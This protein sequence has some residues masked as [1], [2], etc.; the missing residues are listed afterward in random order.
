MVGREGQ[1][2]RRRRRRYATVP[3]SNDGIIPMHKGQAGSMILFFF[4]SVYRQLGSNK[5]VGT[6]A[7]CKILLLKILHNQKND[8]N[9]FEIL[10]LCLSRYPWAH[11]QPRTHTHA[12]ANVYPTSLPS[13]L[14]IPPFLDSKKSNVSMCDNSRGSSTQRLLKVP[15]LPGT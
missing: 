13:T 9:F 2:R 8:V 5:Q 3:Q 15:Y 1:G 4:F 7:V 6:L 12:R 14:I 10:Q 11:T